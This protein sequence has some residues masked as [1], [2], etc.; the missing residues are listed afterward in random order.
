MLEIQ[1]ICYISLINKQYL[2]HLYTASFLS[3]TD[4]MGHGLQPK[5]NISNLIVSQESTS[6]P[7]ERHALLALASIQVHQPTFYKR[8]KKQK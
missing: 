4:S 3:F 5:E 8:T 6:F 2:M 7:S 1:Q